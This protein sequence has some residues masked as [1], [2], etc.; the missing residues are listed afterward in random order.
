MLKEILAGM[1][2]QV[3][4]QQQPPFMPQIPMPMMQQPQQPMFDPYGQQNTGIRAAL[5]GR[6]GNGFRL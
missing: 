6:F 1:T 2:G 3:T 4:G 5:M